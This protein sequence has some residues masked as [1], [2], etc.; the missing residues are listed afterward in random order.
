MADFEE[1]VFTTHAPYHTLHAQALW[2]ADAPQ[3]A[4][5]LMNPVN[6]C[7]WQV[8]SIFDK[9]DT[10]KNG[11]LNHQELASVFFDRVSANVISSLCRARN[12]LVCVCVCVCVCVW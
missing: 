1:V 9:Y 10:Q 6:E 11:F 4:N 8:S 3:C 7:A 5:V 12:D 2:H